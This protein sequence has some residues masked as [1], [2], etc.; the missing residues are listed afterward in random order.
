MANVDAK[1]RL[2][3]MEARAIEVPA[4]IILSDYDR[5]A[6]ISQLINEAADYHEKHGKPKIGLD[7]G[8][9]PLNNLIGGFEPGSL[10]LLAG[11]PGTGK[12]TFSKQ[13]ADQVAQHNPYA[14]SLFLT[15]EQSELVLV[16]KTISRLTGIK[17]DD[18]KKGKLTDDQLS[19]IANENPEWRKRTFTKFIEDDGECDGVKEIRKYIEQVKRGL[20]VESLFVVVDYLQRAPYNSILEIRPRIEHVIAG[21]NSIAKETNCAVLV[22]SSKPRGTYGKGGLGVFKESGL[23]EYTGDVVFTLN[24]AKNEKNKVEKLVYFNIEKHREARSGDIGIRF[25]FDA[26]RC[27][28]KIDDQHGSPIGY[29]EAINSNDWEDGEF[30]SDEQKRQPEAF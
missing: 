18:I 27:K 9:E 2:R 12:T 24:V 14:G 5:Y 11:D 20:G 25:I 28:F 30:K 13:Q 21:L 22:I 7:S 29:W 6:E 4:D 16:R 23:S 19:Q 26:S 10:N 3:D 1:E 17:Y 8:F 15:F